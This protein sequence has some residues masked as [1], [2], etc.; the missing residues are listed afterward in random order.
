LAPARKVAKKPVARTQAPTVALLDLFDRILRH[1]FGKLP[2][3][4]RWSTNRGLE[5]LLSPQ[6]SLNEPHC[7]KNPWGSQPSV[8][9]ANN[10]VD[11]DL[12]D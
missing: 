2:I 8:R 12:L 11:V 1:L 9:V 4:V 7:E 5:S 6:P 10:A 3:Y